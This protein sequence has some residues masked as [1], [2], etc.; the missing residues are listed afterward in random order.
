MAL[1]P[2]PIRSLTEVRDAPLALASHAIRLST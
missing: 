2:A 1:A